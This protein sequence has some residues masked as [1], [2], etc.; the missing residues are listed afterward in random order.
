MS[1]LEKKGI[2]GIFLWEYWREWKRGGE[3]EIIEQNI[4]WTKSA[5]ER[6]GLSRNWAM[7]CMKISEK[8]KLKE[9]EDFEMTDREQRQRMG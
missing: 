1:G 8:G 3:R 7:L 9:N 4:E 2:I 6:R 5:I